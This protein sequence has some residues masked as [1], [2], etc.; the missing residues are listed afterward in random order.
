VQ[1]K[2]DCSPT[3]PVVF[4][5]IAISLSGGESRRMVFNITLRCGWL[6]RRFSTSTA[7]Q[8]LSVRKWALWALPAR[9]TPGIGTGI[10]IEG[11]KKLL[12]EEERSRLHFFEF[13][14]TSITTL[15][16]VATSCVRGPR[17]RVSEV[18]LGASASDASSPRPRLSTR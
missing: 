18:A 1:A 4:V 8:Y 5:H 9:R 10:S 17:V 6:S 13:V 12:T 2:L 3:K 7:D 14:T 15:L 16:R 11:A